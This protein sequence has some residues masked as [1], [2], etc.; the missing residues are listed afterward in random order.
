MTTGLAS[1]RVQKKP[2]AEQIQTEPASPSRDGRIRWWDLLIAF[3]GGHLVGIVAT[4]LFAA[5]ALVIGM[6][7]GLKIATRQD[8][9]NL[10]RAAQVNF[11]A[12]HVALVVSDL[13][14]L[15]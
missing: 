13:G 11:W 14:L 5:V 6:R 3:V 1:I 8:I 9:E 10:I 12:N 7:H 2:M 4:V 15:G